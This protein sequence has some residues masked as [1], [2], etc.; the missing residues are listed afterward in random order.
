MA[1]LVSSLGG[2]NVTRV[3]VNSASNPYVSAVPIYSPSDQP[4]Y[5]LGSNLSAVYARNA[6]DLANTCFLTPPNSTSVYIDNFCFAS[7][8]NAPYEGW[9][10]SFVI[11]PTNVTQV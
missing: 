1:N 6:T 9:T 10:P 5:G 8:R 11:W 4:L 2:S 7:T 3:L